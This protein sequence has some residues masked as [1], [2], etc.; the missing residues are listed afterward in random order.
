MSAPRMMKH[1]LW[2]LLLPLGLLGLVACGGGGDG[3]GSAAGATPSGPR[4][5]I[6]VDPYIVGAM[7]QEVAADGVTEWLER[8]AIQGTGERVPLPAGQALHLHGD[9]GGEWTLSSDGGRLTVTHDHDGPA[10]ATVSG[11][12]AALLLATTR[13]IAADDPRLTV[14]GDANVWRGWLDRTPF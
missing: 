6:A 5:G 11:P 13:R 3:G 1:L 4:A 14:N 10:G 12:A 2:T 8:V 7:F 9:D